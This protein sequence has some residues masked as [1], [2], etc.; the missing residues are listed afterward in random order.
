MLGKAG[1]TEDSICMKHPEWAN[2]EAETEICSC[3]GLG[4]GEWREKVM[5]AN[6]AGE[7]A[8]LAKFLPGKREERSSVPEAH[9]RTEGSYASL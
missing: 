8:R 6:G 5:I 1:H 2:L 7:R 9:A 4:W 3:Q